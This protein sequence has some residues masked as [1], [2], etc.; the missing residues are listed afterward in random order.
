MRLR[1]LALRDDPD[2]D[3]VSPTPGPGRAE[4][5]GTC[6]APLYDEWRAGGHARSATGPAFRARYDRLLNDRPDGAGVCAA[7]HAPGL[8]PDPLADFDLREAVK[9]QGELSGVHCDYCHKVAGIGRGEIGLTH[10]RFLLD[11]R[12]PPPGEQA[13]FGPLD[14][15]DRGDDVHGPFQRDARLCGAC[16]EGNVFGVPVYTTFSEWRASPAAKAG[17]SCQ[18]CHMTPTGTLTNVAPGRGG[19]PRDPH[20]L[21]NHAFWRGSQLQMLREALKLDVRI[22]G[23]EAVVTLTNVGAGHAVPTGFVDRNLVLFVDDEPVRVFAKVLRGRDGASPA[24]FWK[25]LVEPL[26]DTRLRPGVADFSRHRLADGAD[27][28][29]VR[30]VHRRFWH[31]DEGE[32]VV[33]RREVGR[34]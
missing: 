3:W 15:A 32:L 23:R 13:F 2:Y 22:E 6:H 19:R 31:E 25:A 26:S 7:C 28:A 14:D 11:V 16:H 8:R 18:A 29:T 27:A 10:G 4:A 12:R 9:G 30:V 34:R 21:G 24:P 17:K 33:F 5:C 1:R 20:T